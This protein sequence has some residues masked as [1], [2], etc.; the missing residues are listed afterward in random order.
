[1]AKAKAGKDVGRYERAV[2]ALAQAAPNGPD[3]TID[4][5]W[6]D[7]TKRTVR[8]E[9]ERLEHELRGYKNNLI[10]ESIRVCL[11]LPWAS[12]LFET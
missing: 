12:D 8:A 10:K 3:A 9:T 11:I 6:V 5:E 4:Q 2:Q 7:R 1:V